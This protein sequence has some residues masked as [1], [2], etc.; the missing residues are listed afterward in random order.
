MLGL[1]LDII[2][3]FL[4]SVEAI[5]LENVRRFRDLLVKFEHRTHSRPFAATDELDVRPEKKV[6]A[7][8]K[9][10]AHRETLVPATDE[11]HVQVIRLTLPNRYY[12]D[13]F[14]GLHWIA[15]FLLLIGVNEI[16]HG[17]PVNLLV[18]SALWALDRPWYI[19]ALFL[20][21]AGYGVMC[22]WLL[23]EFVHISITKMTVIA[24]KGLD[25]IDSRTPDGTVGLVGFVFLFLGFFFQMLGSYLGRPK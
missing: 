7:T 21:V 25:F 18:H 10:R 2:G 15:G 8:G 9:R 20:I 22:V 5:K 6:P 19:F 12:W 17:L 23:G 24:I 3:A 14:D 4:V 11:P 1:T 13:I 16:T